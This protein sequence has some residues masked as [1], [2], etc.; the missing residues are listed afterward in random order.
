MSA[1]GSLGYDHQFYADLE[2]TAL[3][4][5]RIIVPMLRDWMVIDSVVD[6]GCGDGS[7]LSVFKETGSAQVL[8]LDG[9]WVDQ[10][11]L[12]IDADSFARRALDQ[13]LDLGDRRFDLAMTLE[14]AEHLPPARAAGLVRELTAAAPVVFFSAA[15][16]DQG[17]AH[18]VNEQWPRY[19]ADLFAQHGFKPVDAIRP[20]VWENPDV[21]WWYKQNC[22]LFVSRE[23]CAASP[24]LAAL[25]AQSPA[26]PPAL[27][28]PELFAQQVRLANPSLGRWLKQGRRALARS[29]A[30]RK[31]KRG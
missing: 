27:V 19:W 4:S 17:G 31:A 29:L 22:L 26:T 23:A 7:W 14:V 30:K 18:H 5:A 9:P 10:D 24:K 2:D 1:T 16:P 3:P 15:T 12:K 28:H 11:Q 20:R 25:A 8:G 6:I 13:S 21:C